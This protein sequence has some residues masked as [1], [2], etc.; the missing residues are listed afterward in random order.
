MKLELLST[1]NLVVPVATLNSWLRV[2]DTSE[3]TLN[4]GLLNAAQEVVTRWTGKSFQTTTYRVNF[5]E[6]LHGFNLP[7]QPV[8]S[9]TS[10]QYLDESGTWQDI[11]FQADLVCGRVLVDP[12]TY[13][14]VH[15]W[16]KPV[17][18]CEFVTGSLNA[19]E[20][21]MVYLA[22]KLLVTHWTENRSLVG[23]ESE[24]PYGFSMI[25]NLLRGGN[26]G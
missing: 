8:S 15:A 22:M 9:V 24:L 1:Q 6:F 7:R 3:D 17:M 21:E 5:D 19:Q 14:V 10:V 4:T 23:N 12:N 13:Y 11:T 18:R 26:L 2:N 20:L 16:K 25:C